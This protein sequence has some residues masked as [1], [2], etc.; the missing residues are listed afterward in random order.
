MSKLLSAF[1][2]PKANATGTKY[3][4]SFIKDAAICP[5]KS[6]AYRRFWLG[7]CTRATRARFFSD[8]R[9]VVLHCRFHASS[10]ICS[11]PRFALPGSPVC[12]VDQVLSSVFQ[13]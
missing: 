8:G 13:A 11:F 10:L 9:E 5:E 1:A 4:A 3:A 2:S 6:A 12:D 7:S